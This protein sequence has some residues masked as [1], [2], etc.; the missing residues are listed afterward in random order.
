MQ[1]R[2]KIDQIGPYNAIKQVKKG[3]SVCQACNPEHGQVKG[4]AEC[5][6]IPDKP[7][8]SMAVDVFSKPEVHIPKQIFDCVVLCVNG[9][10]GYAVAVSACKR[11]C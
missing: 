3:R 11:G 10:N 2:L 9:H 1:R 4:E 5:M 7:M 8:E 6:S